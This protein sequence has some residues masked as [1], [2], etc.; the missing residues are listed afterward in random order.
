MF[1]SEHRAK[2]D[3]TALELEVRRTV[4]HAELDERCQG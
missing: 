2:V 3:A 1:T 4:N